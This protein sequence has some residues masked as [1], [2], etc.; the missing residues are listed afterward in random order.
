[1]VFFLII[2]LMPGISFTQSRIM[3]ILGG[4]CYGVLIALVPKI[5]EFV[6]TPKTLISKFVTG[7]IIT[8]IALFLVN[9][10]A[11]H[12]LSAGRGTIGNIDLIVFTIP[13]LFD[14]PSKVAV[15]ITCAIFLNICSII[16]ATLSS[17]KL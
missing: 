12:I 5:I 10:Q 17:K 9:S 2:E 7:S 15:F 3:Q 6:K 13:K 4:L 16:L 8:A 14:L 11:P 1:M